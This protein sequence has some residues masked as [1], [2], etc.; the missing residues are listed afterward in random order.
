M[1]FTKFEKSVCLEI[2]KS[3]QNY[4]NTLMFTEKFNINKLDINDYKYLQQNEQIKKRIEK[5]DY[6]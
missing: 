1:L 5:S 4:L 3:C 2:S 6:Q